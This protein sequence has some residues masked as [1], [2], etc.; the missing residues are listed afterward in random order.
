M[1]WHIGSK[2]N[3]PSNDVKKETK[4]PTQNEEIPNEKKKNS[5]ASQVFARAILM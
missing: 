5:K 4:N 3:F 2:C 1:T